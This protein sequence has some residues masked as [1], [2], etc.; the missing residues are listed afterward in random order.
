MSHFACDYI[1]D[2]SWTV[3]VFPYIYY[4]VF[5]RKHLRSVNFILF[6]HLL[7][8]TQIDLSG[9]GG[10]LSCDEGYFPLC[11]IGNSSWLIRWK[12]SIKPE[13]FKVLTELKWWAHI[14]DF[15]M[16]IWKKHLQSNRGGIFII[17]VFSIISHCN[18]NLL[19]LHV[20]FKILIF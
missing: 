19:V 10:L 1:L 20:P 3:S 11:W 13:T 12:S 15:N 18:Y 7:H 17:L 5:F 16:T 6:Y 14:E 4:T 9:T 8:Q 2:S